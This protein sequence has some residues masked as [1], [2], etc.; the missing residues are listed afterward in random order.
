MRNLFFKWNI[1]LRNAIIKQIKQENT[2]EEVYKM[3]LS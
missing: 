2:G 1:L 3:T